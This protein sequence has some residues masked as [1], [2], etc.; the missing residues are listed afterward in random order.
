MY[1]ADDP[2]PQTANRD[3]EW[4]IRDETAGFHF[5]PKMD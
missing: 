3:G 1:S 5:R 2:K 4:P